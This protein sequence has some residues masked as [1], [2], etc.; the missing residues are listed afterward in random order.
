VGGKNGEYLKPST[1]AKAVKEDGKVVLRDVP[2]QIRTSW[3]SWCQH[4]GCYNHPVHERV[5]ARIMSL[6]RSPRPK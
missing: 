4:A 3:N 2:D 1:T 5:I 6:V